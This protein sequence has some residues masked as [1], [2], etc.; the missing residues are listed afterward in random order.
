MEMVSFFRSV[1]VD[2]VNKKTYN[3]Y[4]KINFVRKKK[5]CYF[6]PNMETVEAIQEIKKMKTNPG[7]GKTYSNVDEMIE[8]LLADKKHKVTWKWRH[9]SAL[10]FV[11]KGSGG[12]GKLWELWK[13]S[14]LVVSHGKNV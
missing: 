11:S 10:A 2:I 3:E 14:G 1:C 4:K 7:I 8:E 13:R 6:M 12:F 9:A 5:R